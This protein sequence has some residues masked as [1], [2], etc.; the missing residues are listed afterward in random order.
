M[1]MIAKI[2]PKMAFD[3]LLFRYPVIVSLS[4]VC[5]V[6]ARLS[7][8]GRYLSVAGRRRKDP[9]NR[10]ATL[11]LGSCSDVG[12]FFDSGSLRTM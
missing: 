10:N 3:R 8:P 12:T 9:T 7:E 6:S 4:D 2:A 1:F 11:E 5:T